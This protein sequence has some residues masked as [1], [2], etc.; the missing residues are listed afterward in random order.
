M[1]VFDRPAPFL[2]ATHS[3]STDLLGLIRHMMYCIICPLKRI[4]DLLDCSC[5]CPNLQAQ[6]EKV[7]LEAHTAASLF[8][9]ARLLFCKV[10]LLHMP[11]CVTTPAADMAQAAGAGRAPA[12]TRFRCLSPFVL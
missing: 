1:H 11:T 5:R 10:L 6:R 12:E 9:K 4:V 3:S 2:V 7:W 8:V